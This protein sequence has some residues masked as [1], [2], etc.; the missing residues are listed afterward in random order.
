MA[1]YYYGIVLWKRD[2]GTAQ[3]AGMQQA[4]GWLRRATEIDPKF[5]EAFLQLGILHFA[6]GNLEQAIQ[7]YRK[8]I[9][10]N[11]QLSEPHYRLGLAYRRMKEETK[12]EQEFGAYED[13][14]KEETAAMEKERRELK[15]FLILLKDQ[16]L[17]PH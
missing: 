10:A 11:A 7:D 6:Q 15:Q 3:S 12:A 1:N 14:T 17:A 4:E 9:H 5:G 13:L 2:R 16:T 8:A